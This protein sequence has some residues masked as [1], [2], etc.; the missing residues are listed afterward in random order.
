[1]AAVVIIVTLQFLLHIASISQEGGESERTDSEREREKRERGQS[2]ERERERIRE[3]E[4]EE[5]VLR[6]NTLLCSKWRERDR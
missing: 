6:S 1:M 4:M 3:R 5:F 2:R